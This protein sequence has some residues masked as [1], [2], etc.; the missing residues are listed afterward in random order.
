[1][2]IMEK[3]SCAT[4]FVLFLVVFVVEVC[5]ITQAF[6]PTPILEPQGPWHHRRTG[7]G[8]VH[9]K[10]PCLVLSATQKE[11]TV[12]G[13]DDT[14]DDDSTVEKNM[15]P[16]TRAS[17]FAV[18][19]FGKVFGSGNQEGQPSSSLDND[20]AMVIDLTRAPLSMEETLERIQLDNDRS[21][22]LS[23]EVDKLIYD[24]QCTFSDPFVAFDGRDRFVDNL[25]NLGSFITNYDAKML[26]YAVDSTTSTVNT[27]VMVKLEL[28]LP[29][30]PVLAWPWGVKYTI[31]SDTNLITT[32][33]ESWDIEAWEGVKQ[34]F[35]KATI[36]I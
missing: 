32:H 1:M 21:Y 12:E 24:D 25:A 33:A 19:A 35:R 14:S 15:N 17:W 5:E 4:S 29:W 8:V 31:D 26:D 27:K 11:K 22:F 23:G 2:K 13:N 34:I 6:Y 18:E 30:K 7:A 36:K 9:G 28:N 10:I 16:L 3:V 20:S